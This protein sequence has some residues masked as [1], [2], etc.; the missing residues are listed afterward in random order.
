LQGNEASMSQII[1]AR[2]TFY[3]SSLERMDT[4]CS[5]EKSEMEYAE[6]Q[7]IG[8]SVKLQ[9]QEDELIKGI[10]I[11]LEISLVF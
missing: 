5:V 2:R 8:D 1:T 6:M 9:E 10:K 11:L 4:A 3:F 7:E